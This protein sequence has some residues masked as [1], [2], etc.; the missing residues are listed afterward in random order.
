MAASTG[1]QIA[2]KRAEKHVSGKFR[3]IRNDGH[4]FGGL[5]IIRSSLELGILLASIFSKSQKRL[6]WVFKLRLSCIIP[7]CK[8]LLL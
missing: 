7:H 5:G 6:I 2:A 8:P 4:I 3:G 1:T